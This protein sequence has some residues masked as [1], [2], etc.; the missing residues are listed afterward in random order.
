VADAEPADVLVNC[1]AVGLDGAGATFARLPLTLEALGG[2]ECVLDFVYSDAETELI[3]VARVAGAGVVDGLE[4]LVRQ[5]ALSF[6]A[7][8][9]HSAPLE[10]M[11]N[12]ARDA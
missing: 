9:G 5:G 2:Y 7:W 4:L 11:R 10:V 12:A 3:A 8:T 1:T 6:E